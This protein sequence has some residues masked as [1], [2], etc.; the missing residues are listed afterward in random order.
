MH[1]AENGVDSQVRPP[2]QYRDEFQESLH[3]S[4]IDSSP[5]NAGHKA[6]SEI[7]KRILKTHFGI[8]IIHDDHPELNRRVEPASIRISETK[9][10]SHQF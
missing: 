3:L 6:T 5:E 7:A 4:Q 10:N 2:E 1:I 9:R 8:E